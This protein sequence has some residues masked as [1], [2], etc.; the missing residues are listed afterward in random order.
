[1][2]SSTHP[3]SVVVGV[4][5]PFSL[6]QQKNWRRCAEVGRTGCFEI[7]GSNPP[8]QNIKKGLCW[9]LFY[10]WRWKVT[11]QEIALTI[12]LPPPTNPTQIPPPQP[13]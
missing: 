6:A 1:M 5:D 10:V 2:K 3:W 8:L 9:P 7:S 13:P 4:T 11:A 12:R